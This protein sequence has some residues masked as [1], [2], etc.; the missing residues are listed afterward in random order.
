MGLNEI[1]IIIAVAASPVAAVVVDLIVVAVTIAVAVVTI[2][3][4]VIVKII[5]DTS[6]VIFTTRFLC[7]IEEIFIADIVYLID[8]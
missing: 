5:L 2:V 3:A 8:L 6:I 1:T 4:A 7:F